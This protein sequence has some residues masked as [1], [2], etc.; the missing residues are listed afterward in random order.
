[1]TNPQWIKQYG[2][3]GDDGGSGIVTDSN[4][5][6]YVTGH[7][8]GTL[9]ESTSGHRDIFVIK[10]ASSDG[11]SLWVKQFG[12]NQHDEGNEIS[13]DSN[14]NVYVTGYTGD[15]QDSQSNAGGRDVFL[16]K[17]DSV[18]TKQ[19]TKLLGSTS[20]DEGMGVTVDSGGNIFATGQT[21]GGLDGNTYGGASL[22][23]L[24]VTKYAPDGT[25]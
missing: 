25:R 4:G 3:N 12:T 17:Y 6:V 10:L 22:W 9:W 15:A 11:T 19:W 23:D 20:D 18:G 1:M 16:V 14:G 21:K 5:N 2:T 13:V 24:F 7:T 8:E